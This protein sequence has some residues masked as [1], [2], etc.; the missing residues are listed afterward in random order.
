MLKQTLKIINM[1]QFTFRQNYYG[2]FNLDIFNTYG[3]EGFNEFTLLN[4]VNFVNLF[5]AF[6]YSKA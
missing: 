2:I 1:P 5:I 6:I 3:V 4:T